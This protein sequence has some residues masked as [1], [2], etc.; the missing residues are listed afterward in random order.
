MRCGLLLVVQLSLLGCYGHKLGT[1]RSRAE[2]L[3]RISFVSDRDG[4]STIYSI[5]PDGSH[6]TPIISVSMI[7][8]GEITSLERPAWS[9]D[10]SRLAFAARREPAT[11]GNTTLYLVNA[12]GTDLRSIGPGNDA[13]WSP[14]GRTIAFSQ[15][16]AQQHINVFL[17]DLEHESLTNLTDYPTTDRQPS[18]SPDGKHIA[19]VSFRDSYTE[20]YVMDADGSNQQRLTSFGGM[21]LNPAWSPDG[22]SIAFASMPRETDNMDIYVIGVDGGELRRVTH[23]VHMD[24]GPSWSP[25]GKRL[26][27]TSSRHG[28]RDIFLIDLD[29]DVLQNL[30]QHPADDWVESPMAWSRQ[31]Q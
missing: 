15:W 18:W 22:S 23:D 13:A 27:F 2:V 26:L 19:F 25:D 8:D 9:P 7:P 11:R 4:R 1:E 10:G 28:N 16:T 30:T 5:F 31:A 17:L 6:L 12:N 3:E 24:A 29:G 20:L 21:T 14:D